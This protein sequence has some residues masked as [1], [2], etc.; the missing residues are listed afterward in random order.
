VFGEREEAGAS[1][2]GSD[3]ERET[4]DSLDRRHTAVTC[5]R[6]SFER[7]KV[8]RPLICKRFFLSTLPLSIPPD[9]LPSAHTRT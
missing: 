1:E 8:L 5:D 9:S 2:S 7:H 3:R 4:C 6:W